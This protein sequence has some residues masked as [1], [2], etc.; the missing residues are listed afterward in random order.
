MHQSARLPYVHVNKYGD[1]DTVFKL[2]IQEKENGGVLVLLLSKH[3]FL[4]HGLIISAFPLTMLG[5]ALF[6]FS[7]L[8]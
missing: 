8:H 6:A 2:T 1:T 7:L 5:S 3:G 4:I